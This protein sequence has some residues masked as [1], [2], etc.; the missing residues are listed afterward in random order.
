MLE[1]RVERLRGRI[2]NTENE[3]DGLEEMAV[4]YARGVQYYSGLLDL[5]AEHFGIEAYRCDDGSFS[6]D[7]LRAKM[8]DLVSD[9]ARKVS[10]YE[11]R[12]PIID[13]IFY[14]NLI[15]AVNPV[16]QGKPIHHGNYQIRR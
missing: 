14:F 3:R 11:N 2:R 6:E 12:L 5:I 10:Y 4:R 16:N 9:L 13:A 7:P 8:P 15:D 1:E